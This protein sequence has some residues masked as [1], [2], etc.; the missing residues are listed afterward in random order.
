MIK[1]SARPPVKT[2]GF[3]FGEIGKGSLA[4]KGKPSFRV[5]LDFINLRLGIFFGK[6]IVSV[7]EE[8]NQ[9][10]EDLQNKIRH[11]ADRL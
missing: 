11:L 9:K 3:L 7:M 2:G 4:S 8:F 1:D 5:I 10:I 6:I